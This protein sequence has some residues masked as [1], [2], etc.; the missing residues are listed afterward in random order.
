MRFDE[1]DF[2]TLQNSIDSIRNFKIRDVKIGLSCTWFSARVN[3]HDIKVRITKDGNKNMVAGSCSC[4]DHVY[5]R[6]KS[7]GFC[8]HVL[9]LLDFLIRENVNEG[10][11]IE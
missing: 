8:K 10:D 5:R 9:Y 3:D 4:P 2:V 1:I 7:N 6:K 11:E